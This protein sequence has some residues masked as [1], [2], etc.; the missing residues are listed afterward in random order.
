MSNEKICVSIANVDFE[1]CLQAVQQYALAELRLD[2]LPFSAEQIKILFQQKSNI[3][4][5][6]R[7]GVYNDD[8]RLQRLFWAID[9]GATYV[10]IE[11]ESPENYRER[12]VERA[13]AKHCK[14]IISYH[15]FENTPPL[16]KLQLIVNQ[17]VGMGADITKLVT[18]A[19]DASD[20]ARILSLYEH[21][22]NPLTAFAMG[23][24][25]KVTR[26]AAPFLGAPFTYAA[27]AQGNGTASGQL[28]VEQMQEIYGLC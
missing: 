16:N 9:A 17:V 5:T 8:E 28:T 22:S 2:L 3:I 1:T 7:A 24:A 21:H 23:E 6:C 11:I 19:H 14:V 27:L 20:A 10:D 26:I 18:T 25:G 4:A 12:L 15:N 13:K